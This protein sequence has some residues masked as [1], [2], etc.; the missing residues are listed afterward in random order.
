MKRLL[1][2]AAV[3]AILAVVAATSAFASPATPVSGS[4]LPTSATL[5]ARPAGSNAVIRGVGTFVWVGGVMDG[6]S[7]IAVHFVIH[8]ARTLTYQGFGTYTGMT[9]CGSATLRLSVA[10]SGAFPGPA[11]G[12]AT[13]VNQA[14]ATVP[15]HVDLDTVLF[16]TPAGAVLSYT[17]TVR[18]G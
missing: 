10:G 15:I 11:Y 8:D 17:G 6:T 1:G 7:D 12:H 13:V 9:P 4:I 2:C 14:D 3:A 18:C 16:L 5:D